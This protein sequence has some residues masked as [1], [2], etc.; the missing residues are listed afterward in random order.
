[1]KKKSRLT[2]SKIL[3]M[4]YSFLLLIMTSYAWMTYNPVV[5]GK[6]AGLIFTEEDDGF[7]DALQ[8][9]DKN[10]DA[11]LLVL[12]KETKEY[13][14]S[15][16]IN[17]SLRGIVP[18]DTINY[19]LDLTNISDAM[20]VCDILFYG[21][22][23]NNPNFFNY[24]FAGLNDIAYTRDG[25]P[26]QVNNVPSL[27]CEPIDDITESFGGVYSYIFVKSVPIPAKTN[28]VLDC[29]FYFDREATLEATANAYMDIDKIILSI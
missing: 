11:R 28:V 6:K 22:T 1:M 3:I 5:Y 20:V 18:N 8:V 9:T 4:F 12:N 27:F 15:N 10:L 2:I 23:T 24:L 14:E 25:E 21:I 17:S 29:F 13:E 26:V 19:K 16:D 7:G